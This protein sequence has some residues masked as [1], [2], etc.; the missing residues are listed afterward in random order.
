MA[1]ET[2]A[3]KAWMKDNSK[4]YGVR[5]M[6]KSEQELWD[7]LQGKEASKVIKDALREYIQNHKG[8]NL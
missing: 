4:I 1:K 7:F 5:I 3:H 8:D 2:E 6:K